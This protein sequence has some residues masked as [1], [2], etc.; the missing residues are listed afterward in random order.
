VAADALVPTS[1]LA[2]DPLTQ[3]KHFMKYLRAGITPRNGSRWLAA[4]QIGL[5]AIE[6]V[7]GMGDKFRS[8]R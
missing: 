6:S 8:L 1:P 2:E 5:V 4:V 3:I 7:C